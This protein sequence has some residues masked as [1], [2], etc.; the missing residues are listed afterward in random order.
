M[1]RFFLF[2]ANI[3]MLFDLIG[4]VM[5]IL[6]NGDSTGISQKPIFKIVWC[7]KCKHHVIIEEWDPLTP[8]EKVKDCAYIECPTCNRKVTFK[9]I[10]PEPD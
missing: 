7:R 9:L 5:K 2:H 6:K 3:L 4:G 1:S 8:C 10:L